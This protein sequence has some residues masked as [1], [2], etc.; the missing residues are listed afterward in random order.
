MDV[1]IRERTAGGEKRV[2]R[3]A[4]TERICFYLLFAGLG[5]LLCSAELVFGV[6]PFGVALAAAACGVFPAVAVGGAI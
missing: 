1:E 6:R 4:L 2:D 5:A 3:V